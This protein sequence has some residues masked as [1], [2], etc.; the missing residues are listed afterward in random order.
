VAG[1]LLIERCGEVRVLPLPAINLGQVFR[2]LLLA[3]SDLTVV[4]LEL[5]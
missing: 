4:G 2:N 5:F 1:F 3:L